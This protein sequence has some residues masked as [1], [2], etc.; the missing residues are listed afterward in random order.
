MLALLILGLLPELEMGKTFREVM[1]AELRRLGIHASLRELLLPERGRGM[2]TYNASF[3][4]LARVIAGAIRD[5][6]KEGGGVQATPSIVEK[7]VNEF[8]GKEVLPVSDGDYTADEDGVMVGTETKEKRFRSPRRRK[9]APPAAA[10]G[11]PPVKDEPQGRDSD[12]VE[13]VHVP[14]EGEEAAGAEATPPKRLRRRVKEEKEK[15]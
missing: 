3:T 4:L 8:I 10:L 5:L 11:A 9:R 13:V 2:E 7:A 1:C 6:L 14:G 12:C 15:E